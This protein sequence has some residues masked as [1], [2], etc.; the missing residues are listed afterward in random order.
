MPNCGAL[1]AARILYR[2]LTTGKAIPVGVRSGVPPARPVLQAAIVEDPGLPTGPAAGVPAAPINKMP[3]AAENP[4]ISARNMIVTLH[5]PEMGELKV[6]GN[7]I[8]VSGYPDSTE[9]P[10]APNLDEHRPD[11]LRALGEEAEDFRRIKI[12]RAPKHAIW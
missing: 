2:W 9:R 7:P 10:P 5:D 1:G 12:P 3:Q 8:K 6:C 4:Q 11:I